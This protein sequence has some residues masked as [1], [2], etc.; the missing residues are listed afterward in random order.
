MNN[1]HKGGRPTKYTDSFYLGILEEYE[2]NSYSM[3]QKKHKVSR[4]TILRWLTKGRELKNEK[5][6]G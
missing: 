4:G 3:L 2:T 1:I 5:Q 6:Q